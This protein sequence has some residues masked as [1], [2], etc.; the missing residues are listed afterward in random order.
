MDFS[1]IQ[2][3]VAPLATPAA[4]AL[5]LGNNLYTGMINAGIPWGIAL[6][7]AI[8]A[9]TGMEL[10]GMLMCSMALKAFRRQAFG[11][12]WLTIGGAAIY[13]LF[14]FFGI[15]TA[16]NAGTFATMVFITLIAYL[17]SGVYQYFQDEFSDNEQGIKQTKAQ[18]S[19]ISAQARLTKAGSSNVS[20]A[21]ENLPKVSE[22][23]GS[24]WRRIPAEH[25]AKIA[26]M[27]TR[28]I[29][30]TYRVSERTAL[31]WQSYAKE[32]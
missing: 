18:A 24:D 14:V 9:T 3:I 4:P 31:N 26:A 27:T 1:K 19:L 15:Y 11:V 10:S 2:S 23:F 20:L 17:G 13:A 32:K 22:S 29:S 28:Q 30:E 12:M 7:G 5:M 8:T 21:S 25:R 16:K 6:A